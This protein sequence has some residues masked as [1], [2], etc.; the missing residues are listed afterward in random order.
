MIDDNCY[1]CGAHYTKPHK[2]G[3]SIAD[4]NNPMKARRPQPKALAEK[5]RLDRKSVV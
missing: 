1:E 2:A 3:C 4:P 5:L